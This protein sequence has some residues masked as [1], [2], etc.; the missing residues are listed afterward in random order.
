MS[1]LLFGLDRLETERILEFTHMKI[2]LFGAAIVLLSAATASADVQL[3]L[4]NGRV[5]I[6]AKDASVRQ[7]LTEWARVGHTKIVN[8]E[9]IP[10]APMTL[11]LRN[12]PETQALDILMRS[13]SGYITALR[14]VE[15]ANLSQFDRIIV[16]PTVAS[17][18][19]ATASAPP[20]VFQQQTPQ[21]TQQQPLVDDDADDERP[22]PNVTMPPNMVVPPNPNANRGPVFNN[23]APRGVEVTPQGT[24]PGMPQGGFPTQQQQQQQQ[25]PTNTVS[26]TSP[27]GGVA[28]PGMIVAPPPQPGQAQPGQIQQQQPQPGQPVRRPGGQEN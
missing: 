25:V 27:F 13:L 8:V 12:I 24:Y 20:P 14:A 5:T 11:E 17:A 23:M 16:M 6:V 21:F 22:A 19:P 1:G 18:R 4:Q 10:G 28:V 7:I 2:M 3:T 9:R 26:P 15:A